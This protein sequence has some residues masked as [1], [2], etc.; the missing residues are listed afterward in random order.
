M[1]RLSFS[2][3][4]SVTETGSVTGDPGGARPSGTP[5]SCF[6]PVTGLHTRVR[7][8]FPLVSE[9]AE[10]ASLLPDCARN[11]PLWARLLHALIRGYCRFFHRLRA[12]PSTLPRGNGAILVCNHHAVLDPFVLAAT[13]RRL[14]SFLIAMEY[15]RM[16]SM[17]WFFDR[18][19]C[20]P[21]E[22]GRVT[23][24]SVRGALE[25]LEEGRVLGIFPEGGIHPVGQPVKPKPGAALLA[26]ETGAPVIPARIA[27]IRQLPGSDIWTFL[28]PWRIRL[29][30]GPPVPLED[31]RHLYSG[32]YDRMLL[33]RA[34]GRII[35]AIYA[36]PSSLY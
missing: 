19:G 9:G 10:L 29:R 14:I 16:A 34:A 13:N 4:S 20:V 1:A 8:S 28:R 2:L 25:R 22:R 23:V 24:S 35:D 18:V 27:G 17:R 6:S 7:P 32:E 26:L 36:L 21:V 11:W 30:Y 5:Y 12:D 31:L 3:V 15:Y 33:N